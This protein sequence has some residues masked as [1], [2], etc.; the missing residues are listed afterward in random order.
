MPQVLEKGRIEAAPV[1]GRPD[2]PG[3][4]IGNRPAR[5]PEGG[6]LAISALR[7]GRRS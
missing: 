6:W 3:S 2:R 4:D 5:E 1:G 7:V